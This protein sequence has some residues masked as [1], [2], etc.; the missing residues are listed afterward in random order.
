MF[1][2]ARTACEASACEELPA[3]AATSALLCSATCDLAKRRGC[4]RGRLPRARGPCFGCHKFNGQHH[5]VSRS[6]TPAATHSQACDLRPAPRR[7]LMTVCANWLGFVAGLPTQLKSVPQCKIRSPLP[8]VSVVICV[9]IEPPH[10]RK[11]SSCRIASQMQHQRGR[12][13]GGRWRSGACRA[14]SLVIP[15]SADLLPL[16]ATAAVACDAPLHGRRLRRR[17]HSEAN[18]HALAWICIPRAPSIHAAQMLPI[19]RS[20]CAGGALQ[21]LRQRQA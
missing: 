7:R 13:T 15:P 5:R 8:A 17:C 12:T 4:R 9:R 3:Q 6:S 2:G 11:A 14:S 16:K 18:H 21:I 10:E 1:T 20:P 19:A